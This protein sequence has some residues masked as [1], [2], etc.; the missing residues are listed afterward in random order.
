MHS[1]LSASST[2]FSP[3]FLKLCRTRRMTQRNAMQC[4]VNSTPVDSHCTI[5]AS[6]WC[7][8]LGDDAA[9]GTP[10]ACL[11]SL[12]GTIGSMLLAAGARFDERLRISGGTIH[13]L[14]EAGAPQ[15]VAAQILPALHRGI[16][17]PSCD[18]LHRNGC[19]QSRKRWQCCSKSGT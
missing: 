13:P 8:F 7:T 2:S 1:L 17:L 11:T 10:I 6:N 14:H 15:S 19:V 5:Q 3:F 18:I 12:P 16:I 4:R 9:Q